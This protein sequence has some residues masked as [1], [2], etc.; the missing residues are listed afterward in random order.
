MNRIIS[1]WPR[2]PTLPPTDWR[3]ARTVA[4]GLVGLWASATGSAQSQ[5]EPAVSQGETAVV[6]DDADTGSSDDASPGMA[7]RGLPF[8]NLFGAYDRNPDPPPS[9]V[10]GRLDFAAVGEGLTAELGS[11]LTY[12]SDEATGFMIVSDLSLHYHRGEK[13]RYGPFFGLD[14]NLAHFYYLEETS[15]EVQEPFEN[16]FGGFVGLRGARTSVTLNGTFAQNNGDII[17]QQR[18][19]QQTQVESLR[20]QSND[21]SLAFSARRA[22]RRTALE[23]SL[24]YQ[25][26][27]FTSEDEGNLAD[28]TQWNGSLG[29]AVTIPHHPKSN[30][31][32]VLGFGSS[33]QSGGLKDEYI[34]P[35]IAVTHHH[36]QKTTIF[37]GVGID[38]RRTE[39]GPVPDGGT[40]G[41]ASPGSSFTDTNPVFNL[42]FTWNADLTTSVRVNAY[43]TQT[44]SA[45][46]G[47]SSSSTRGITLAGTKK[48]PRGYYAAVDYSFQNIDYVDRAGADG[49]TTAAAGLGTGKPEYYQGLNVVFGRQMQL[50]GRMT[51]SASLFYQYSLSNGSDSLSDYDQ[52]LSGIRV[53]LGF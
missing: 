31:L 36:N 13:R 3:T 51:L 2:F 11:S 34:R 6:K 48:L 21:Y 44:A 50:R 1:H 35:A 52:I 27:D 33:E 20:N 18:I 42:G 16:A 41:Q 4:L 17:N 8:E 15:D 24:R 28:L 30:F 38:V 14:Y 10:A 12:N 40:A 47:E 23:A 43:Q 39:T 25:L 19:E 26:Q 45:L 46:E 29:W 49:A 32:P 7:R 22:L 37:G 9:P 53:G 5:E